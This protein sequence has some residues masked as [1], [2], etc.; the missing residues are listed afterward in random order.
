VGGIGDEIGSPY[1]IFDITGT[2]GS[3]TDGGQ[4]GVGIGTGSFTV[5]GNCNT[6]NLTPSGTLTQALSINGSASQDFVIGWSWSSDGTTDTLTLSTVTGVL[7]FGDYTA[8]LNPL[9]ASVA[10][11]GGT[12]TFDMTAD[13]VPLPASVWLFGSALGLL[14]FRRRGA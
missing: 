7:N 1:D 2:S 14:G 12:T 3:F 10:N 5:G 6:C 4:L 13:I 11:T 8:Y 9:P